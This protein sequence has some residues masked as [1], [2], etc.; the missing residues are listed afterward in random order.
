M[1]FY[2]FLIAVSISF[3]NFFICSFPLKFANYYNVF[4]YYLYIPNLLYNYMGSCVLIY[5]NL[6]PANRRL[7]PAF[8]WGNF[9]LP[10][11]SSHSPLHTPYSTLS[12]S[13]PPPHK[14]KFNHQ[15]FN[16]HH[17]HTQKQVKPHPKFHK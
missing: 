10:P 1:I 16:T 9:P 4:L 2:S 17:T 5:Q 13:Y 3:D 8:R 7:R 6:Q 11:H 14:Q 15:F 12:L